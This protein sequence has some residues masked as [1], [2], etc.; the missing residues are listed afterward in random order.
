MIPFYVKLHNSVD[1]DNYDD[2]NLA[3]ILLKNK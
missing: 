2:L 3:K 1:I